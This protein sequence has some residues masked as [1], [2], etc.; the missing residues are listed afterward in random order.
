MVQ[1]AKEQHNESIS[2]DLPAM[3]NAAIA[4]DFASTTSGNNDLNVSV[5][6][7]EL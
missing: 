4:S 7:V 6:V 2:G 5:Y 1:R 3:L